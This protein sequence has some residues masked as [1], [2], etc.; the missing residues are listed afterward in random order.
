VSMQLAAPIEARHGLAVDGN[1]PG[2]RVVAHRYRLQALLGRGGMGRVWLAFDGALRRP[3]ALK[4]ILLTAAPDERAAAWECA[5]REA[6]AAARV[7]HGGAVTI[8]DVVDD[9]GCPWI[10]M[11]ALPGRTLR[12]VL[13]DAG[14][15][16]VGQVARVGLCLLDVLAQTHR[17]GI[18]HLDVKPS[19]VHLCDD[20][21]VVLT[22]FGIATTVAGPASATGTFSGSPAYIAPERLDGDEVGPAADLFSLGA[23][24]F[25]AVE[26]VAPFDRGSVRDTFA[27]VAAGA[28]APF[29]R[30]GRLRPVIEGLLA[31]DPELRPGVDETRAALREI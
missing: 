12:E 24:L 19:N 3:V 2:G 14:P 28:R 18:V 29:R 31:R 20:E 23:T 7:D 9:G 16:P 13:D 4:Q 1:G 15:L 5:L 25:A 11:E 8:F 21:R 6:R 30:A 17:A 26:G 27:A 10:V 22:D